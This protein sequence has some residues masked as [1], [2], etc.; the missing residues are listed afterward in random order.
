MELQVP[1]Y[2][3]KDGVAKKVIGIGKYFPDSEYDNTWDR[4]SC[5]YYDGKYG[6]G[7]LYK[8]IL[9]DTLCYVMPNAFST[10]GSRRIH[11]L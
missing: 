10:S 9:P 5:F 3:Y 8:L 1:S 4:F 11:G 2:V 7:T 6:N